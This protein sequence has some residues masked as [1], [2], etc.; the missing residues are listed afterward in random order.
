M[1]L[2]D[3]AGVLEPLGRCRVM[4]IL[5]VTPDSFSD[6]GAHL[7]R[8]EAIRFGRLLADEGADI[9]DVG[10]ESTRPGATRVDK[11]EELR[12]VLPVVE[13]LAAVGIA[14]S[15][16]TTRAEVAAAAVAA[17]AVMV[18]DTSG[19]AD[20]DLLSVVATSGVPYVLMHSRGPSSQMA[21][22]AHYSHVV[23]EVAAELSQR[24]T[25]ATDVGVDL[26]QV[27]LDPG[28]G[29]AKTAEQNWPLLA[30]LA[31]FA[32]L[33]RPVLV[34]TSRKSFLGALLAGADRVARP[35]E[36]RE[37]AT[38]ATTA[39]AAWDGAWGV[40]VHDVRPAADAVRVVAAVRAARTEVPGRG[41]QE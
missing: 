21:T 36:D 39:L 3:P 41:E 1:V 12:R 19:G 6:G 20:Q 35:V 15:I 27:V 33:G 31:V 23:A 4:G 16:D 17:G 34:G 26:A 8:E 22:Q 5:N 14:I 32:A 30:H 9:V 18:N 40:R 13:A 25:N 28:I 7:D 37:A 24:L 10:G 11:A 2:V 29:F 38:Q